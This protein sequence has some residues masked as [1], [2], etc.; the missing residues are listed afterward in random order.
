MNEKQKQETQKIEL[1][2][3]QEK[4]KHESYVKNC[5]EMRNAEIN[6]LKALQENN[7]HE[8]KLRERELHECKLMEN[9]LSKK[10]GEVH[11]EVE[12]INSTNVKRRDRVMALHNFRKI[13]MLMKERCEAV[14]RDLVHDMNLLDR[15]SFDKE[16][17]NDEEIKYLRQKFLGQYESEAQNLK[18]IESMYES[19]AKDALRKQEDKWNEE[20]MLREQQLKVL[21]DDRIQTLNERIIASNRKKK[22]LENIC[23]THLKAIE[24]CNQRL[25]ELMSES[26][27]NGINETAKLLNGAATIETDKN[28]NGLVR[29]TD[30][31]TL[32][33]HHYELTAP[34]YGRK[35]VAW[36]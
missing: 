23:S 17:D 26:L 9:V 22:E 10:L 36:T 6:Q 11:K 33:G 32:N 5:Q 2:L 19:E 13:K 12:N 29:K 18:Y 21:M 34:K 28:I 27:S 7:I 14:K 16:F 25:K 8:H 3:E 4:R 1:E 31:L 30:N 15:I 35:K 20:G 24:D